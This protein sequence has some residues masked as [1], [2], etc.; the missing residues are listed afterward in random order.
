MLRHILQLP[1]CKKESHSP[2]LHYRLGFL[3]AEKYDFGTARKINALFNAL[4]KIT[5]LSREEAKR[6]SALLR[7]RNLLVHH[8]GV[9]TLA[10]LEQDA[11]ATSVTDAFFQSKQLSAREVENAIDFLERFAKKVLSSS[12]KRWRQKSR[13]A[14]LPILGE[15]M[16]ALEGI[17]YWSS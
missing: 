17:T 14:E 1:V 2:T 7:D 4:L 3:L 11:A 15:R 9:F 8:G 10:Y 5:P 12:Q 13:T 16:K 6:Y